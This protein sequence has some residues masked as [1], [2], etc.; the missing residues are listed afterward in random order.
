TAEE[1]DGGLEMSCAV[2]VN[3]ET[4]TRRVWFAIGSPLICFRVEGRAAARRTVTT[5]FHTGLTAAQLLMDAPG[6]LVRRPRA[7]V[8]EPTFWPFQHL[9]YVP[10]G[11][12]RGRRSVALITALPGA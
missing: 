11:E 12:P 5:R 6:G 2:E 10:A 7:K 1:R 3:G 9:Y 8:Y 4:I